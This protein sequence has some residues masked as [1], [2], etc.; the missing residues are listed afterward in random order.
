MS[1][2]QGQESDKIWNK[3][4]GSHKLRNATKAENPIVPILFW[5]FDALKVQIHLNHGNSHF[6]I[7]P[8]S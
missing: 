8:P 7:F 6:N 5:I 3:T 4:Y 1:D 2:S